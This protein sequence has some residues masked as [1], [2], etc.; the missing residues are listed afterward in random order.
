V[1]RTLLRRLKSTLIDGKPL[2]VLPERVIE[3]ETKPFSP[4]EQ[5]FYQSLETS[6]I[7][8]FNSYLQEG[9]VMQNYANILVLLLRLR[10]ACNHPYLIIDAKIL[11]ATQGP[12]V[13]DIENTPM[14]SLLDGHVVATVPV[15]QIG[16]DEEAKLSKFSKEVLERLAEVNDEKECPICFDLSTEGMLSLFFLSFCC[17]LLTFCSIL[18]FILFFFY[19]GCQRWRLPVVTSFATLASLDTSQ[20]QPTCTSSAQSAGTPWSRMMLL[21]WP[22]SAARS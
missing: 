2:I 5:D 9:T 17:F 22:S 4:A 8:K 21:R 14:V 1:V 6:T 13:L 19:C 16:A 10:Q 7:I 3:M 15:A 12:R 18:F 11:A 20:T